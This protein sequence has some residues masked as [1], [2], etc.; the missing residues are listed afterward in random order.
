MI[1]F[2]LGGAKSGKTKF[3]LNYAERLK[4]FKNYYYLAT[5]EAFDDEM[6]EK[7]KKHQKERPPFWQLIEEP[8]NISFHLKN[9]A[10]SFSII[11]LDCLTMWV[12]NLIYYEKDLFKEFK[13]FLEILHLYQGNDIDWLIIV[14]NEVGL[15]LVPENKLAREFR[16]IIGSFN[17]EIAKISDEV[18]FIIAGL[19][20]SLKTKNF[21]EAYQI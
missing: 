2:I 3:A 6:R 17:Q 12:S 8:V 5:A 11:L 15:G 19:S 21:S 13:C 7:I 1:T 16:E 20:I 14:S 9:L 18:Y 10:K 4:G